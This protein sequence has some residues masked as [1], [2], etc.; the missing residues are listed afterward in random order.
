MSMPLT[1]SRFL[2]PPISLIG[3]GASKAVGD[4]L[5]KLGA[6]KALIVTDQGMKKFGTA[7][8]IKQCIEEAGL[9]AVIF[10]GAEPNPTDLNVADGVQAYKDNGC[11]SIVSL[12]GGSSHD[13]GKAVGIVSTNGGKIHDYKGIDTVP[14]PMPPF[15]A[16]N[17]T[18]G[19]GSEVTPAAVITNTENHVKMVV[20][21]INVSA[22]VAIDDPELMVG[23]PPALTAATGMD[24]LTHAV[25]AY[26]SLGH[27]PKADALALKAIELIA[28]YLRKAV[29]NGQDMDARVGMAYAEYLAGE[30]FSSAGLGIAHSLA[31]Q[32]GSFIGL[33]HG[34]CNA[35]FLPLVCEFNM[36]ACLERYADIAKAMGEDIAG[37]TERE[38]ALLGIEAI[39]TLSA[40]IGIPSGLTELGMKEEDIPEMAEWALKEVCTPTNPRTTTLQDMVDLYKK[41]M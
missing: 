11:D 24:A 40:D 6:K 14:K 30:A 20:W 32:P 18:A 41:A 31:H 9:Q 19:T 29:A 25:E 4:Y 2:M 3:C 23:M 16:I 38:A 17:T 26:V 21:S 22:N 27:N 5:K 36:N 13:C 12:G 15:I 7:D 35:I 10:A 33:P 37:M 39:R 28:K 1:V 8:S 34:V